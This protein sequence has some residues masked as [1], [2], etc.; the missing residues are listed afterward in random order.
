MLSRGSDRARRTTRA[1]VAGVA[2]AGAA[3]LAAPSAGAATGEGF[4][5]VNLV[6]DIRGLASL[7]DRDVKNP[8][9]IALGSTTPLWVANNGTATATI[10]A[11]ANGSDPVSKIPL[12]VALPPE[13]TG[14]V[15]NPTSEFVVRS[16]SQHAASRFLFDTITSHLVGWSPAV[17]PLTRARTAATVRHHIYLGL[18][19]AQTPAGVRLYAAD[20]AGRIDVFD[21]QWRLLPRPHAFRDPAL[22]RGLGPYNVAV[23]GGNVYVSYAP[24]P[25]A[26]ASVDG[27]IDVYRLD[28]RLVRRLVTGGALDDPWGMVLAPAHWG[29][30]GGML[31]VGN[32]ENGRINAFDPSTGAF[33]GTLRDGNGRAIVHEGLWGLAFGNGVFG[34]PQSLIFAA[35]IGEYRHGLIGIIT[36]R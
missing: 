19:M 29:R 28:G 30:F 26:S 36:P 12:T 6:S 17:E 31:L 8:W 15:F 4:R 5:S 22:P 21:G 23:L 18:A 34:T 20:G 7:T 13:P 16:G 25:G 1:L 14:Q 9:G 35:G 24:V 10:Y 32:E 27:V 2:V 11:G 33:R 3:V